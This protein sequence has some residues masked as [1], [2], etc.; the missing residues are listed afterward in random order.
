MTGIYAFIFVGTSA[1][2]NNA[3]YTFSVKVDSKIITNT[4]ISVKKP[5]LM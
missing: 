1:Y 4:D 5:I 3:I 2:S